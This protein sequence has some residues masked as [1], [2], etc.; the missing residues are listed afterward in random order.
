MAI[1]CIINEKILIVVLLPRHYYYTLMAVAYS[2]N[3]LLN[4]LLA[5]CLEGVP[6]P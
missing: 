5:A 1:V 2:R 6:Y 4:T 3:S